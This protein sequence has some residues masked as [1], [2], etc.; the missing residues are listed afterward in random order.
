LIRLGTY[1]LRLI[2]LSAQRYF[3]RMA[4]SDLGDLVGVVAISH[5]VNSR[6]MINEIH[7]QIQ[8]DENIC[9]FFTE[10]FTQL[11]SEKCKAKDLGDLLE[12]LSY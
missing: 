7:D 4:R 2:N 9:N 11:K 12:A 10:T 1:W 6:R 8:I 5:C 3:L